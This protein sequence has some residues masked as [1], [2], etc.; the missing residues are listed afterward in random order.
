MYAF[1]ILVPI[2]ALSLKGDFVCLLFSRVL[3]Y[4]FMGRFLKFGWFL[5][6][7]EAG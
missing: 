7:Y 1:G 5:R 6:E 2:D 3:F 4:C